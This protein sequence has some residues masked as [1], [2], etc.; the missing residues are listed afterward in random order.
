MLLC[1]R[2][3]SQKRLLGCVF[4]ARLIFL[5]KANSAVECCQLT[6]LR[7]SIRRESSCGFYLVLSISGNHLNNIFQWSNPCDSKDVCQFTQSW[8][9]SLVSSSQPQERREHWHFARM[10]EDFGIHSALLSALYLVLLWSH[11]T[12]TSCSKVN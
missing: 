4:H 6:D 3:Y 8:S 1:Y 12:C 5:E 10:Q 2:K 9:P 11:G 7:K